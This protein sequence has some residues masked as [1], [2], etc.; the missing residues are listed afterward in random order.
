MQLF[1]TLLDLIII[2]FY[3]I[4]SD[5]GLGWSG[6]VNE[7][8]IFLLFNFSSQFLQFL[9]PTSKIDNL[10]FSTSTTNNFY[11]PTYVLTDSPLFKI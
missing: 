9:I 7:K 1:F 4:E 2:K 6:C 3:R 11:L 8:N 5:K 10:T